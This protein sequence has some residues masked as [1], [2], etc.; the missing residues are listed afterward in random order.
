MNGFETFEF[1]EAQIKSINLAVK[2]DIYLEDADTFVKYV[3]D[4]AKEIYEKKQK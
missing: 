1:M 4:T 2:N 3:N